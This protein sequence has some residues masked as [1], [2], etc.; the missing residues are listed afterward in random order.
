MFETGWIRGTRSKLVGPSLL[1]VR[2][3]FKP[4]D[5]RIWNG[6]R[7][8]RGGL[9]VPFCEWNRTVGLFDFRIFFWEGERRGRLR[10]VWGEK[11]PTGG[12]RPMI[13]AVLIAQIRET[14]ARRFS[15]IFF[16]ISNGWVG[17]LHVLFQGRSNRFVW[18]PRAGFDNPESIDR[19]SHWQKAKMSLMELIIFVPAMRGKL[20]A[21]GAVYAWRAV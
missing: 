4:I 19:A 3:C 6:A 14:E 12:K 10:A 17:I 18:F 21:P 9:A 5:H 2:G 13:G 7:G 1:Y 8:V 16:V 11:W 20:S 15:P